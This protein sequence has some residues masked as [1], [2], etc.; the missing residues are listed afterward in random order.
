MAQ[1]LKIFQSQL[2]KLEKGQEE[3]ESAKA[4]TIART[5]SLETTLKEE[6]EKNKKVDDD[7]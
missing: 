2:A 6:H 7:Y 5:K 3:V 4:K 1:Q